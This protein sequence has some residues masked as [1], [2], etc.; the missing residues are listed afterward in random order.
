[1][2]AAFNALN[3]NKL[4]VTMELDTDEG[5]E[6]FSKLVEKS[7]ILIENNAQRIGDRLGFS[8]E[9]LSAINPKLILCRMPPLGLTG[10]YANYIGFGAHFEALTALTYLRSYP[11][12][13]IS[14]SSPTFHMDDVSPTVCSFMIMGAL[15]RR[16]KTGEGGLIEVPQAETMLH[17]IGEVV[18]DQS[19]NGRSQPP[20]GNRDPVNAPQGC[21]PCQGEDQWLALSIR[22]DT[23]WQS[24]ISALGS[25]EW[26]QDELYST[27]SGR[28]ANHDQLDHHLREW[29]QT[30]SKEV[31]FHLLQANGIPCAPLNN[32]ADIVADEHVKARKLL[33]PLTQEA[34]GTHD[35]PGQAFRFSDMELRWDLPAPLLGEHNEYVYKELLEYSD[36]QYQDLEAKHL[37][38]TQYAIEREAS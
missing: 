3:R 28:M 5:R 4:S 14:Q 17:Q 36:E 35:Y 25:P 30:Q 29:S 2:A 19:M 10:P 33:K 16:H 6:A 21:Y 26:A 18:V 34:C 22:D 20:I 32:E 38:G 1:R 8:W 7:D 23:E 13:D 31:A 24:M 11:D 12:G 27:V 9:T 15:H 37:I